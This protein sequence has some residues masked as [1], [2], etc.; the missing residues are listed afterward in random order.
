MLL[1]YFCSRPYHL[2]FKRFTIN[3]NLMKKLLLLLSIISLSLVSCNNEET[4][5]TATLQTETP[6]SYDNDPT[7]IQ[8]KGLNEN[9]MSVHQESRGF[10]SFL[11]KICTIAY[12]DAKGAF[13]GFG[14]G[15]MFGPAGSWI[16]AGVVGVGA[17][18][19]KGIEV[20]SANLS[21]LTQIVT[22]H[23]VEAAYALAKS[24]NIIYNP[25]VL[26][27]RVN[28]NIPRKYSKA[29]D[30]GKTHNMA[31][32]NYFTQDLS[33]VD[34]YNVLSEDEV[35]IIH[36]NSFT[37]NYDSYMKSHESY[38][39][40]FAIANDFHKAD[41]IVKL[42]FELYNSYPENMDDVNYI[43][44]EYIKV[45]ESDKSISD[46][47]KQSIYVA[48]AV[49]AYSSDYWDYKLEKLQYDSSVETNQ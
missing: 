21:P 32:H 34:I 46:V 25:T 45:I 24:S 7:I 36:S 26:G 47:E 44:N 39:L 31:L 41:R 1:I 10:W 2:H 28:I 16:G 22:R 8:L 35:E 42:F 37:Y 9:L 4:L 43:I 49:T 20:F 29:I 18:I 17:S 27:N 6:A 19:N 23:D 40:D 5:D 13:S 38:D 12:A 30:L 33:N 11:K 48:F 3:K 14:I 15:S